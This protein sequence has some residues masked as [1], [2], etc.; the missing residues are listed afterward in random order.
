MLEYVYAMAEIALFFVD[1]D[2]LRIDFRVVIT[3]RFA[4]LTRRDARG[5]SGNNSCYFCINF[6]SYCS[7]SILHVML[8]FHCKSVV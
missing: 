7:V 4:K 6:A 5:S 3:D 8:L 1:N 2:T